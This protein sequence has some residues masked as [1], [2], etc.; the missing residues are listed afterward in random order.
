MQRYN[1]LGDKSDSGMFYRVSDVEGNMSDLIAAKNERIADLTTDVQKWIRIAGEYQRSINSSAETL[2]VLTIENQRL[3]RIVT[4]CY[5]GW[6]DE[7]LLRPEEAGQTMTDK[8]GY[9]NGGEKLSPLDLDEQIAT[10]KIS[11]LAKI[12][13][14]SSQIRYW[15]DKYDRQKELVEELDKVGYKLKERVATLTEELKKFQAFWE[16]S[17]LTERVSFIRAHRG[18]KEATDESR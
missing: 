9:A 17:R 4:N 7:V 14:K 15:Q 1:N 12:E 2:N 8:G 10:L 16:Q 3:R 11:H 13:D 18:I 5:V 6:P